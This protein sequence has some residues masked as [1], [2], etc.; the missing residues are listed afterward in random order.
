MSPYFVATGQQ[1]LLPMDLILHDFKL[2]AG[3]DFLKD[4]KK[5]WSTIYQRESYQAIKDKNQAEKARI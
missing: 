3:E 4:T 2:P 5:L 1:P